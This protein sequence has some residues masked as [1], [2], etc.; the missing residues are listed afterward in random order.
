[1][2]S[3]IWNFGMNVFPVSLR[4]IESFETAN[5]I[6]LSSILHRMGTAT[7]Y[8]GSSVVILST[9]CSSNSYVVVVIR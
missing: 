2:A 6:A 8:Y 1:M 4:T 7:L 3:S 5:F 9:N